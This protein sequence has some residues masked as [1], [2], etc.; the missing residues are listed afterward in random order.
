MF[1]VS[2]HDATASLDPA[3]SGNALWDIEPRAVQTMTDS[4]KQYFVLDP[5][6]GLVLPNEACVAMVSEEMAFDA[7]VAL[8]EEL[9]PEDSEA[10]VIERGWVLDHESLDDQL[11]P[12]AGLPEDEIRDQLESMD[13]STAAEVREAIASLVELEEPNYATQ[14]ASA[15]VREWMCS[16]GAQKVSEGS[17]LGGHAG[18]VE[19]EL[20]QLRSIYFVVFQ[21]GNG[22]DADFTNVA[23][24]QDPATG[25]ANY[26]AI[27]S[28]LG[29]VLQAGRA[30][31][32]FTME[33]GLICLPDSADPFRFVES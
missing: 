20:W 9:D 8:L 21:T 15:R 32:I 18:P 4:S 5:E 31:D 12:F 11:R 27:A 23:V 22:C 26:A 2:A 29:L 3:F 10:E 6:S 13:A 1:T 14:H 28:E 19:A 16:L 33:T 17:V 7:N 30:Q 25:E 24:S